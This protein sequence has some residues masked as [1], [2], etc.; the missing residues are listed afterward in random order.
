MNLRIRRKKIK[1]LIK[2]YESK[3]IEGALRKQYSWKSLEPIF[4]ELNYSYQA[5]NMRTGS[6]L[7]KWQKEKKFIDS[8][9]LTWEDFLQ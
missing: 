1:P 2:M 3:L 6:L 5:G 8:L 4:E 7:M 9:G